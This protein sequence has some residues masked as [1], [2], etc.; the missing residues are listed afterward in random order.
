MAVTLTKN[1]T[2]VTVNCFVYFV[3]PQLAFF[4]SNNTVTNR[5]IAGVLQLQ[6]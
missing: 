1:G 3:N 4:I 2:T 5:D 6:P